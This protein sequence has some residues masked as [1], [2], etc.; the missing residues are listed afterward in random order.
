MSMSL[1]LASAIA[2]LIVSTLATWAITPILK[3]R[4]IV[5]RP[6]DRSSHSSP[7]PR[8]GGIGLVFGIVAGGTIWSLGFSSWSLVPALL[9]I[10]AFSA[11]G[12]LDDLRDGLA[13]GTRLIA[14]LLIATAAVWYMGPTHLESTTVVT[15]AT[16]T[17]VIIWIVGIVNI[18][19]FLDGI[20]G[21]AATQAVWVGG[22]VALIGIYRGSAVAAGVGAITA[23]AA[24]GFLRWNWHPARVFLGDVGSYALGAGFSVMALSGPEPPIRS[25]LLITMLAWAFTADGIYTLMYRVIRGEAPWTPHRQHLY[26][27]L[28]RSGLSH[29]QVVRRLSFTALAPGLLSVMAIL[30]GK[31]WLYF[32]G[33]IAGILWLSTVLVV[34]HQRTRPTPARP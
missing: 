7:V 1:L 33:L 12:L 30:S 14:Q 9:V 16:W 21:Y 23:A 8:G 26:Q 20:D 6:N 19:N 10:V 4:G 25:M 27:K 15:W 32:L 13:P 17:A 22:A 5:D 24:I 3:A 18:T 28:V 34:V 2:A 29:S 11:V 31:S